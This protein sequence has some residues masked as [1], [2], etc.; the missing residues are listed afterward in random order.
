M[1]NPPPVLGMV[2]VPGLSRNLYLSL[3]PEGG[4]SI[5]VCFNRNRS[6]RQLLRN[7]CHRPSGPSAAACAA[8]AA[9]LATTAASLA[10]VAVDAEMDALDAEPEAESAEAAASDAD[11]AAADA[12]YR[13][14]HS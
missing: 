11:S 6:S 2:M 8:S 9:T 12:G 13:N 5:R 14:H 4:N 7:R 10:D 1:E 3:F